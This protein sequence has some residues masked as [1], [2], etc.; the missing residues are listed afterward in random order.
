[1]AEM[2]M[3]E[4]VKERIETIGGILLN[5]INDLSL[6]DKVDAMNEIKELMHN[7]SPFKAEPVDLI[8]W[9]LCWVIPF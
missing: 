7:I 2:K 9:V 3:S 8:K 6:N 4:E 1:M 5:V